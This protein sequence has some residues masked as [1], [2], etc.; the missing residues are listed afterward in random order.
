MNGTVTVMRFLIQ[1]L[2]LEQYMR[3]VIT[4]SWTMDPGKITTTIGHGIKLV[5]PR[6]ENLSLSPK[7]FVRVHV[8]SSKCWISEHDLWLLCYERTVI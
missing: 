5:W 7:S 8:N 4:T 2:R 1:V 6:E 3:V